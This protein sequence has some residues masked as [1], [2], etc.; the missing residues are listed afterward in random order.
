MLATLRIAEDREVLRRSFGRV[1]VA[2]AMPHCDAK[3]DKD[4]L[5]DPRIFG[6]VENWSCA[7]GQFR[8]TELRG[9]ICSQ[10]GVRIGRAPLLRRSRFGH[11]ELRAPVHHPLDA[12]RKIGVIPVIPVAYR[13]DSGESDLD[14]LYSRVLEAN[15]LRVGLT[16][17]GDDDLQLRLCQLFN[18][19]GCA[20]KAEHQGKVVRSLCYYAFEAPHRPLASVGIFLAALGVEVSVA[21]E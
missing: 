3:H 4:T 14:Y 2:G 18:N 15:V 21:R 1:S 7:C 20:E 12:N 11:I 19:E 16:P 10:C 5:F 17:G 13:S 9:R 8:G 6:P